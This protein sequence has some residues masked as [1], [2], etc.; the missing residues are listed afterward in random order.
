MVEPRFN[1]VS[2][3]DLGR[4]NRLPLAYSSRTKKL[5]RL[6]TKDCRSF[7]VNL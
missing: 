2:N 3:F 6:E 5:G 1:K 4:P 7:K